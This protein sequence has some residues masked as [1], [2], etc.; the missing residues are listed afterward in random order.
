MI[1]LR[2]YKVWNSP[3]F[4]TILMHF[5][6]VLTNKAA[7][8]RVY[9]IVILAQQTVYYRYVKFQYLGLLGNENTAGFLGH[10]STEFRDLTTR[11]SLLLCSLNFRIINTGTNAHTCQNLHDVFLQLRDKIVP[12]FPI[13]IANFKYLSACHARSTTDRLC[14]LHTT[15]RSRI[16]FAQDGR[17]GII[18]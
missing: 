1:Y 7:T 13:L 6:S 16:R 17:A 9:G 2:Y 15:E 3:Q 4:C 18:C 8:G 12:V 5:H 11:S 14:C 10:G